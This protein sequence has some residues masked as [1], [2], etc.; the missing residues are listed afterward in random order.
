MVEFFNSAQHIKKQAPG[1]IAGIDVLV[2]HLKG[3]A[4][5]IEFGSDLAEVERDSRSSRATTCVSLSRMY[6][7][8]NWSPGLL[9]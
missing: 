4:L 5:A 8:Q 7:R 6:S 9:S 2:K 1:D 3:H